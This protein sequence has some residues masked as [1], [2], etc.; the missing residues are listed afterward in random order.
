M[1]N[2]PVNATKNQSPAAA[3]FLKR[4]LSTT[5]SVGK[6]TKNARLIEEKFCEPMTR[7]DVAAIRKI[8]GPN[9]TCCFKGAETGML[10]DE[11]L[12]AVILMFA[13]FPDNKFEWDSVE[14]ISPGV[15]FVTN[16]HGSGTHTGK[17]FSFGQ[18]PPIAATGIR[19]EE[20]PCNVTYTIAHNKITKILIDVISGDLV[21]PP[22]YYHKIGGD[23]TE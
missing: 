16:F 14:E 3:G 5:S 13:S 10:L 18:F 19:V 7:Q 17:P 1:G 8:S 6:D 23:F 4:S 9:S 21:G 20:D 2:T 12:E 11:F 22:G 15:V